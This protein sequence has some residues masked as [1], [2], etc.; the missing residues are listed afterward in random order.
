MHVPSEELMHDK[1][2]DNNHLYQATASN[3]RIQST[4]RK[5]PQPNPKQHA[6]KGFKR[7]RLIK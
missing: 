6:W 7:V 1:V 2:K 5:P 3:Q 4:P